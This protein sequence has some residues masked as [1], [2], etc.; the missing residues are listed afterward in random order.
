LQ[1]SVSYQQGVSSGTIT[2]NN[3]TSTPKNLFHLKIEYLDVSKPSDIVFET[4]DSYLDQTTTACGPS[5][6]GFPD[7]TNYPG[8]QILNDTFDSSGGILGIED[9]LLAEGL[10]IY[11]NPVSDILTIDSKIPLTRIEIFSILGQ[12]VREI[13]S[14]FNTIKTDNLSN[15]IYIIRIY[16]EKGTIVSKLIKW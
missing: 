11:P 6:S 14:E 8:T 16:S 13:N 5:G 3:V 9:N 7:C 10:N 12:R 15:S 4:G 1:V 2:A